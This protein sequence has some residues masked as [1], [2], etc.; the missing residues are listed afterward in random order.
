M[1]S[2]LRKHASRV[3]EIAEHAGGMGNLGGQGRLFPDLTDR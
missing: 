3:I 2:R 1:T